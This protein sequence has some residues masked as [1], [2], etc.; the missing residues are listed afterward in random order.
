M[1]LLDRPQEY[2]D[3]RLFIGRHWKPR[4]EEWLEKA[5]QGKRL[6]KLVE[7]GRSWA[8]SKFLWSQMTGKKKTHEKEHLSERRLTSAHDFWNGFSSYQGRLG[9]LQETPLKQ[10]AG[11]FLMIRTIYHFGEGLCKYWVNLKA[12]QICEYCKG[13]SCMAFNSPNLNTRLDEW[14]ALHYL[15]KEKICSHED[16][17][18]S[19]KS[20]PV[21]NCSQHTVAQWSTDAHAMYVFCWSRS[22]W[23]PCGSHNQLFKKS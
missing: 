13:W 19:V 3:R 4:E 2:R 22:E 16:R 10:T 6:G 1:I 17:D 14:H 20:L 9:K 11:W 21:D 15:C 23:Q 12:I 7:R 18:G 8:E 5:W